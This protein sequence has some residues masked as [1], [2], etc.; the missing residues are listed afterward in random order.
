MFHDPS[1]VTFTNK[2]ANEIKER[3]N[4]FFTQKKIISKDKQLTLF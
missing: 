2:A 4:S 1:A 3:L